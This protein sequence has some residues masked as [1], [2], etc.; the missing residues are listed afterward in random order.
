MSAWERRAAFQRRKDWALGS[1][2]LGWFGTLLHRSNRFAYLSYV[3]DSIREYSALP[4]YDR[5]LDWWTHDNRRRNSGD[6]PRLLFLVQN[7]RLVLDE[8]VVGEFAEV[9]VYKGNSSKVL[10]Y[11]LQQGGPGR[12]LYL[13][14]TFGGFDARDLAGVDAGVTPQFADVSLESVQ[15]F[16][17]DDS[18]CDYRPGYFPESA[19]GI[20]PDARFALVHLDCDLYEPMRAGLLFFYPRLSLGALVILHDYSSGHW[21]GTTR[22]VDEFLLDKPERLLLLPDKSGTAFF[23][24]Q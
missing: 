24:K 22:A 21:P 23:R 16:V 1:V 10:K 15:R 17:G 2:F 20:D 6:I 8:E 14:D 9:G 13:F 11:V 4:E 18:I 12:R 5:L 19:T 7:A 3:P